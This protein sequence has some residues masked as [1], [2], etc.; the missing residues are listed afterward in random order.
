MQVNLAEYLTL[1]RPLACIDLETTGFDESKDRICQ[2]SVTIHYPHREPIQWATL[3]DPQCPIT[4][5]KESHGITD[6]AV[7]GKPTFALIAPALAPKILHVDITGYNPMFDI[8]FLR[9]EM[10]RAGVIWPWNNHIVDS[11]TIYK[12]KLPHNLGNAYVEYGGENG[13]PLP[14]GSRLEGAHQADVDVA[15]SEI[16]L[17]GQLL[18]HTDLPRDVKSLSLWCFPLQGNEIDTNGKF[19]WIDGVPCITFGKYVK[20]NGG[21]PVPMSSVDRNYWKFIL[22]NDFPADCKEIAAAAMMG[23]Y[24]K[25][26]NV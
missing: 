15:A 6:E 12:R 16:V 11:W 5:A 7:R 17:R 24:P 13:E 14:R 2:I 26:A 21:K 18:R 3:V 10:K 8:K 4:N 9:A 25:K 1:E 20:Q 19:V 22:D 23:V